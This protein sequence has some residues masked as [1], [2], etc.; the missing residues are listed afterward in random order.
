MSAEDITIE[1]IREVHIESFRKALDMVSRER[2]YLTLLEAPPLESVREFVL[3]MIENGHS[4]FVAVA[5]AD[6]DGGVVVGWCDIRG[7][8]RETHAHCGT[9]GMGIVSGYRDKGLGTRLIT[10]T[11]NDAKA[12]G[13]HRVELHVHADNPRA[14]ALYEKVGFVREG[15][16]RDAV[17]IDGRYIDAIQMAVIF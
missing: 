16:A 14:V 2:K 8:A 3:G 12:R 15:V 1:P 4:Q 13:L 5:N 7:H 17:R 10:T 11:L 9:L 6:Q